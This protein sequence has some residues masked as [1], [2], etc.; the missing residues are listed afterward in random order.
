[1]DHDNH[2]EREPQHMR[3]YGAE[4]VFCLWLSTML[5]R[6]Y[7]GSVHVHNSESHGVVYSATID[8]LDTPTVDG[9]A[10]TDSKVWENAF[11]VAIVAVAVPE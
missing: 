9:R 3:Q 8:W 11:R 10:D 6:L 1:M 5:Q 4:N 2:D 7:F